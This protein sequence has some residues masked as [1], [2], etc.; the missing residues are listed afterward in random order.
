MGK[1]NAPGRGAHSAS[2]FDRRQG[3]REPRRSILILC[4]G[5]ETEPRY[6]NALKQELKLSSVRIE[7]K[8]TAWDPLKVVECAVARS[9]ESDG[10]HPVFDEVWCVLDAERAGTNP[11]FDPAVQTAQQGKIELAVSNPAFEYWY[12]LHFTAT[13][14]PFQD[15]DQLIEELKGHLPAY[16]KSL[17]VFPVLYP[18][19]E[20]ACGR[21][22][23]LLAKHAGDGPFPN[24]CTLVF[25]LVKALQALREFRY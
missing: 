9:R 4:G 22:E 24:P 10:P 13:D 8:G 2:F 19:T 7:I 18:R 11:R 3:R 25:K 5:T 1:G 17:S 15:A 20:D 6:F 23:K 16:E 21:A 14:R 12:L